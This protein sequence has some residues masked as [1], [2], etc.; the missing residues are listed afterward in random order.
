MKKIQIIATQ[1]RYNVGDER[2]YETSMAVRPVNIP[3]T[4]DN[5]IPDYGGSE[6][7]K[8]VY[9]IRWKQQIR[10][11]INAR[12]LSA[13]MKGYIAQFFT[14]H[15]STKTDEEVIANLKQ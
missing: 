1:N 9:I 8:K 12:F 11:N 10:Y 6:H 3:V 14:R 7:G 15:A 5:S 4:T 13:S 2:I